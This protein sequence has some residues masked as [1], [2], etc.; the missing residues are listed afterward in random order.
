MQH[1]LGD[2]ADPALPGRAGVGDQDVEPAEGPG[3]VGEGGPH[4]GGIGHVAGEGQPARGLGGFGGR[5]LVPVEDRNGCALFGE[6]FGGGPAEAR[7]TAGD[8]DDVAVE[9]PRG[10]LAEL[11]L[12]ERPVFD[13]EDVRLRN[14]LEPPDGLRRRRHPRRRF[15]DVGADRSRGGAAAEGEQ[16][17]ARHQNDAGAGVE[18]GARPS[19]SRVVACEPGVVLCDV[20]VERA[21]RPVAESGRAAAAFD[22][23]RAGPRADHVV[24]RRRP[25]EGDAAEVGQAQIVHDRRAGAE[26]GYHQAR[27]PLR[28][29]EEA[30]QDRGDFRSR[31][32]RDAARGG[33]GPGRPGAGESVLGQRDQCDHPLIGLARA[34]PEREDAVLEQDQP[35]DRGVG[36]V[37]R[38]ARLGEREAGHDVGDDAGPPAE[39]LGAQRRTVGLVGQCQDRI[40][41]G[42]EDVSVGEEG[43]EQRLDRR[44]RGVRIEKVAALEAHHLPVAEGV[45]RTQPAQRREPDRRQAGGLD[46]SHVPTAALDA[47]RLDPFAGQVG[48]GRL[49]R[50][51]A[52][53]VE[54]EPGVRAEQ[55]GRV[56]EMREVARRAA[57]A[58]GR[59]GLESGIFGP[60]AWHGA[61][62]TPERAVPGRAGRAPRWKRPSPR[63]R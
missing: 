38:S 23:Q 58:P 27:R 37:R 60:P 5:G 49:D 24:G 19:R 47:Q 51:V 56:D 17:D 21:A 16:A 63:V 8:R 40:R 22:D 26:R 15:G 29:A 62:P 1:R 9:P 44:V 48:G 55:P 45:E 50:A 59:L 28:T 33:G 36:V 4:R 32:R 10:R 2:V 53:A 3:E 52:A 54:H 43:M 12:F 35:F 18:R 25:G 46:P 39:R 6:S 57:L 31:Q 42:M 20:G 7:P 13:V 30:A 11:R 14:A 34:V 41:V 61:E